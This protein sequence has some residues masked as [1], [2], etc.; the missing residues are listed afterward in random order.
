MYEQFLHRP[1]YV[2]CSC[3]LCAIYIHIIHIIHSAH[4]H[5]RHTRHC[6]IT[7][8]YNMW[9]YSCVRLLYAL[10]TATKSETE[11]K[12]ETN[13]SRYMYANVSS[14]HGRLYMPLM[15]GKNEIARYRMLSVHKSKCIMCLLTREHEPNDSLNLRQPRNIDGFARTV[16]H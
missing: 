9:V 2:I 8:M 3:K 6:S 13:Y 4:S 16:V 10:L 14:Q 1:E 11:T 12:T 7:C 5:H 15:Y